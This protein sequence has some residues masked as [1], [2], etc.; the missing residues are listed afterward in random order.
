MIPRDQKRP[1]MNHT[2][3][4]LLN[5]PDTV[6]ESFD[7][8]AEGLRLCVRIDRESA[9]CPRCKQS[10][11][12]VHQRHPRQIRDL[13]ISG[14]KVMLDL[15]RRRFWCAR[16]QLAFFEPVA[17]VEE[18]RSYTHRFEE[19]VFDQVRKVTVTF[20]AER[21]GLSW[22]EIESIFVHIAQK[23]YQRSLQQACAEWASMR[24]P[25]AKAT[26]VMQ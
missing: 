13:S 8:T 25:S 15:V 23:K 20:V 7:E 1:K 19:Y 12:E 16:C 4:K 10:T 3:T 2:L 9:L 22:D 6:V 17:F 21:E 26:R 14:Q 24:S 5:L 18:Y 11:S